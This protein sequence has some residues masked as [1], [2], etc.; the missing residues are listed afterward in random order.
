[1][2]D[3]TLTLISGRPFIQTVRVSGAKNV[4]SNIGL[5]EVRA[6]LRTGER[7]TD[8]LIANLH[9]F[10]TWAFD[11]NDLVITWAM[12]GDETRDLYVLQWGRFKKG[13]FNLIVS[14]TGIIDARALVV[15]TITVQAVDTTTKAD[16]TT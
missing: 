4:W 12:T 5:L 15:P 7:T 1:M 10:M 6:Q 13:Y 14:D 11:V 8:P 9:D 16:G 2:T 3:K